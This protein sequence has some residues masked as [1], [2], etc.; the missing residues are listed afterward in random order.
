MLSSLLLNTL[1]THM[2]PTVRATLTAGRL[3]VTVPKPRG[4]WSSYCCAVKSQPAAAGGIH[5]H[6][7]SGHRYIKWNAFPDHIWDRGVYVRVP[8]EIVFETPSQTVEDRIKYS[9]HA[10]WT[11]ENVHIMKLA[12]DAGE[13]R[14]LDRPAGMW[15]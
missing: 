1:C 12:M 13:V 15:F 14:V 6:P 10:P 3:L 9:M 11:E 2:R 4:T 8:R 7:Q 5:L